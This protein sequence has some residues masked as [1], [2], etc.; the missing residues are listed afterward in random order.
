MDRRDWG[1]T[2]RCGG[3]RFYILSGQAFMILDRNGPTSK[4]SHNLKYLCCLH[5]LWFGKPASLD[6]QSLS[7]YCK[8]RQ[9]SGFLKGPNFERSWICFKLQTR[10]VVQICLPS[11]HRLTSHFGNLWFCTGGLH[12]SSEGP[13]APRRDGHNAFTFLQTACF[14][15]CFGGIFWN[16]KIKTVFKVFILEFGIFG[17]LI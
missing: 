13:A 4:Q 6:C 15:R 17:R 2:S 9:T 11:K 3:I 12:C 16:S 7:F 8:T 1:K 5:P 14:R 10:I